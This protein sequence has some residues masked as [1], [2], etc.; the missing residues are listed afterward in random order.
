M[1]TG[2]QA[3]CMIIAAMAKRWIGKTNNTRIK[4][5]FELLLRDSARAK[6]SYLRAAS[7]CVCVFERV[8]G[9]A[10]AFKILYTLERALTS[11]AEPYGR[12]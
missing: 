7:A 9:T 6:Q 5:K 1:S 12:S 11:L 8:R 2:L 4:P 3:I 10:F